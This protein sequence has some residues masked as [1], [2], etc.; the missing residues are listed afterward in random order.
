MD[1]K[2]KILNKCIKISIKDGR[3]IYG[4]LHSLDK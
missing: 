1:I 3:I 4:I 2:D